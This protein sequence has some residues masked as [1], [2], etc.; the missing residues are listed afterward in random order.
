M[1]DNVTRR[2]FLNGTQIAIGSSVLAPWAKLFSASEFNFGLDVDYYPPALTGLRGS[3]DG[4]WETMHARVSG[5]KW[6]SG[7]YEEKYDLVVVGAGISG[8]SAAYTYKKSRPSARIL[9]LDNHDDFGG[10]AKRNEFDIDGRIRIGYGGTE[11]IDTPS[12]Y[13]DVAK[14]LLVDIGIDVEKFYEAFDQTL[15]SSMGLSKGIVF[16]KETFGEQKLVVGYNK[17]PWQEFVQQTPMNDH[18]KA[19]L[20]RVWTDKRD[21]LPDLNRL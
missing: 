2:D 4:S 12:A 7:N 20:V 19:D 8:L 16:D 1:K 17:I 6:H 3:H 5:K 9:I 21:Y 11:A 18:A 10:H 13:S 15:Y 14:Q